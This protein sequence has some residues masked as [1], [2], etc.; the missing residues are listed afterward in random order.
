[1]KKLAAAKKCLRATAKWRRNGYRRNIALAL[2][3]IENSAAWPAA[4]AYSPS[5]IE[6]KMAA[7]VCRRRKKAERHLWSAGGERKRNE[8]SGSRHLES[9]FK[10][11]SSGENGVSIEGGEGR[12]W[13]HVAWRRR[14]RRKWR[15]EMLVMTLAKK[16][17]VKKTWPACGGVSK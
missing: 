9:L 14:R 6:E 7:K 3:S 10:Y 15:N 11:R 5:E 13:R 8:R 16:L 1:V 4:K 17:G 2:A 12:K